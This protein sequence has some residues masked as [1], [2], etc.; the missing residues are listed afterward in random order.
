MKGETYFFKVFIFSNSQSV[1]F[2]FF[3]GLCFFSKSCRFFTA[4]FLKCSKRKTNRKTHPHFFDSVKKKS[5]KIENTPKGP[6][7]MEF[8]PALFSQKFYS[9]RFWKF[10][11]QLT[12]RICKSLSQ[13][14]GYEKMKKRGNYRKN[15]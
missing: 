4:F 10:F 3:K 2:T 15:V 8:F 9:S 7:P 5:G 6:F 14:K 13:Q 11:F 12:C 1:F